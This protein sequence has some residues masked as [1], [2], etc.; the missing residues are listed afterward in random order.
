MRGIIADAVGELRRPLSVIRG[1]AA[2]YLQRGRLSA[3][4]LDGMLRRVE[5]EAARIGVLVDNLLLTGN[6]QPRPPRGDASI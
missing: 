6:D 3:S 4:E 5:Y 1:A 2:C